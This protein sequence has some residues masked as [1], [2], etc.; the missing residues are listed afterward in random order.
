[1]TD[2]RDTLPDMLY[3]R[4]PLIENIGSGTLRYLCLISRLGRIGTYLV[5]KECEGR[6]G[7][8]GL[9]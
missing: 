5:A 8:Y 7:K 9:G 3:L 6:N 1:M 2:R 4:A